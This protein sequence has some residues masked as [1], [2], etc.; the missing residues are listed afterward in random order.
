[1]K[2]FTVTKTISAPPPAVWSI[3][4]NGAKWTSWDSGVESFHGS[5]APG[6]ELRV[7]VK[8]NPGRTFPVRVAEFDPPT[9]M[10]WRGGMPLGLFTGTRTYTLQPVASGTQFTMEEQYT[11]LLA[12]LFTR[13]IPDLSGSFEQFGTGLKAEAEKAR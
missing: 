10:V 1:M 4:T 7:G 12:G 8:A 11:G 6:K 9:R 2:S 5:I 3:L 13:S